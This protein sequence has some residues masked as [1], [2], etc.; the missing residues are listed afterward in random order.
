M[1]LHELNLIL[2][3]YGI[4]F[5]CNACETQSPEPNSSDAL[6][7]YLKISKR[8]SKRSE[9]SDCRTL[10]YTNSQYKRQTRS[11]QKRRRKRLCTASNCDSEFSDG[12][13]SSIF[14]LSPLL[15]TTTRKTL[16]DVRVSK[17]KLADSAK[18]CVDTQQTSLQ[19]EQEL[20]SLDL[21]SRDSA[22]GGKKRDFA[23]VDMHIGGNWA[24]KHL[25]LLYEEWSD[26]DID[27]DEYA[28]LSDIFNTG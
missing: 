27:A 26:A 18:A 23:D 4:V 1:Q 15:A 20:S 3:H 25:D 8:I 16:P 12:D 10:F 13:S 22:T 24:D 28:K 2:A 7:N 21:L 9:N 19:S 5:E 11:D 14:S 6:S 17:F